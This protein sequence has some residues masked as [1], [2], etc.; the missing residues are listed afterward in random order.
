M[1]SQIVNPDPEGTDS[2]PETL[3]PKINQVSEATN[4]IQNEC[5]ASVME[6]A[7]ESTQVSNNTNFEAGGSNISGQS[8]R[9]S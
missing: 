7:F 5:G 3:I 1:A 2:E 6:E 8:R 9:E 4:Q